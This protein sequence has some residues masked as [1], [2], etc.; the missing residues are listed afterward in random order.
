[1]H[2]V[3]LLL[4]SN[5][6][7]EKNLPAAVQLLARTTTVVAVSTVYEATAVGLRR[8]P[9][10]FNAAALIQTGQSAAA[11]KDGALAGIERQLGR[12]RTAD[13]NA[14]RT[15]DLDI[16]LYGDFV[17]DYAPADGRPRHV[18]SP[19]LLRYAYCALPV[20]DLLPRMRHPE[21]DEPLVEVAARLAR[22]VETAEGSV[23]WP[24]PDIELSWTG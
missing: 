15:I 5:I 23:I 21:T 19:D 22:E 7:K 13:K 14:P 6:D 18:P 4:G 2:R 24:R 3:V 10:F 17:F 1:M 20:A 16:I 11:L 9:N 12:E 8:Q